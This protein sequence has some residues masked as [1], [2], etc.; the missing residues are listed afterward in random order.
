MGFLDNLFGNKEKTESDTT[1]LKSITCE[2]KTIYSPL[3]GNV[4]PLSSVSDPVFAEEVMGPGVGIEPEEGKLYAPVDG[5]IVSVFPTGHAIG[6]TT[7]DGMEVL[8]H[9]GIDTVQLEGDGFHALVKQGDHVKAGELLVEFDCA[10][11]K[12]KGY[13]TT[14][15]VLVPNAALMGT[16]SQP[17]LGSVEPLE[18]IL[19]FL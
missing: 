18:Q 9:I 5:E 6:M 8:L 16:M 13:Q 17:K 3:K 12:E 19:N 4:I 2:P 10:K 14:T 7:G 11:I 1:A 15:M